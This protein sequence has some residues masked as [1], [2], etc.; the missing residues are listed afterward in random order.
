MSDYFVGDPPEDRGPIVGIPR[1]DIN[2]MA[3]KIAE[4]AGEIA[5]LKSKAAR[6][7]NEIARLTQALE[8][9]TEEKRRAVDELKWMRGE[10]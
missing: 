3:R 10:K 1:D 7:R 9:A 2:D 6:Q 5:T 8:V 4:Q